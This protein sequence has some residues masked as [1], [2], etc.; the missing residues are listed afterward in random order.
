MNEEIL[1]RT[2]EELTELLGRSLACVE[3]KISGKV[4][5]KDPNGF[6]IT[7]ETK[8]GNV[9]VDINDGITNTDIFKIGDTIVNLPLQGAYL[10]AK[11]KNLV[12]IFEGPDS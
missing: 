9:Q 12:F 1:E 10:D 5:S 3:V 11:E 4:I 6:I 7:F 8:N 2:E